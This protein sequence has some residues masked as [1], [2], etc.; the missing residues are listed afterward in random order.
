MATKPRVL[1]QLRI[2]SV[3]VVDRGAGEGVHIK[4]VKRDDR[5]T[6]F[7]ARETA[8]QAIADA[9]CRQMFEKA[10]RNRR[11]DTPAEDSYDAYRVALFKSTPRPAPKPPMPPPDPAYDEMMERAR[12]LAK[13][14]DIPVE[15]AFAAIYESPGE[16]AERRARLVPNTTATDDDEAQIH[17]DGD[18]EMSGG[19][20]DPDAADNDLGDH[21]GEPTAGTMCEGSPPGHVYASN[22]NV[23]QNSR[24][25]AVGV[26]EGSYNDKKRPRSALKNQKRIDKALKREAKARR[27]ALAAK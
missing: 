17:G 5:P 18:D 23:N 9:E 4:I 14:F 24:M 11:S 25:A 6:P 13:K 26:P 16:V 19:M 3:D 20:D 1:K 2:D 22:G 10:N 27:R 15:Q 21:P 7:E 12:V 8:L